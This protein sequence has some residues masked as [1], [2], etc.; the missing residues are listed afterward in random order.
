VNSDAQ[1]SGAIAYFDMADAASPVVFKEQHAEARTGRAWRVRRV[2]IIGAILALAAAAFIL[3]VARTMPDFEVYW[4]AGGRAAASEPLYREADGHYQFKYLPGFAVLVLPVS[5]AP[6]EVAKA[7]WFSLSVAAL[8]LLLRLS[9]PL[10]PQQRK[11]GWVLVLIAL[12]VLG[13]FYG[14][15]LVLG[16]VN[17][18]FAAA[19]T[20]SILALRMKRETL[21]GALV[22]LAIVLKP[23]GVLLVPWLGARGQ[24]RAVVTVG[25]G[26]AA[27][28]MLPAVLYG[29]SGNVAL[30][31]D[32]LTTVVTTSN[33]PNI[34]NA[35]NVSWLAMYTRWYGPGSTATALATLTAG[36]AL[37]LVAWM[38]RAGRYVAHPEGLEGALLLVLIPLM[39]PQGWDYVLLVATPAVVYLANYEDRLPRALRLLT[40][41][42]LAVIGLTTFDLMGRA[43]YGAFMGMSGLTLCFFVVI[44]A[45][46]ILRW[47][48]IA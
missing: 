40:F 48:R 2:L 5:L 26:L 9:L 27:V 8:A 43:A 6:L 28:L 23:Y 18:L 17:L 29:F 45:L 36:A 38:W 21:A 15:E 37:G 34:L 24:P 13:K 47:R 44:A 46:A 16:Q 33:A 41:V 25:T 31:R 4:R 1:T 11:P 14:H 42:A 39:S 35:D 22:A 30:H 32:W 20:G 3:R 7:I 12:A 10:L 19:A